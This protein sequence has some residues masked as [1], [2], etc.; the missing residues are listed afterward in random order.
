MKGT[1]PGFLFKTDQERV[2]NLTDYFVTHKDTAFEETEKIDGTS[3]TFYIRNGEFGVC[4]RNL[5]LQED[6]KNTLWRIVH[7]LEI[8]ELLLDLNRNIALQGEIA[9]EGIQKNPLKIIGHRFVIFDV[10]DIDDGCYLTPNE[11][12]KFLSSWNNKS[13]EHVP[14]L[15]E[16]VYKIKKYEDI[17]SLLKHA[18]GSMTIN[19]NGI[20]EGIVYK[21]TERVHGRIIS[22]KVINNE[23]LL[24]H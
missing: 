11:R 9:G 14:I 4:S 16:K 6:E 17:P 13:L 15:N 18:E 8:K 1:F 20:R 12:E 21:S 2:Q 10:F 5:E 3:A 19:E 24:K 23:F 22:F 7:S